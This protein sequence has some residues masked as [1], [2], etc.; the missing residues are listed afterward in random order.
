MGFAVVSG[1]NAATRGSR[2]T[3]RRLAEKLQRIEA[4]FARAGTPGE[5]QAAATAREP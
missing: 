1:P 5:R 3:E 4:L 2:R